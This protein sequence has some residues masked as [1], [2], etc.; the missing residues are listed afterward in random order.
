[1]TRF[2]YADCVISDLKPAG[3]E[4]IYTATIDGQRVDRLLI[5]AKFVR[6]LNGVGKNTKNRVWLGAAGFKKKTLVVLAMETPAGERDRTPMEPYFQRFCAMTIIPIVKGLFAGLATVVLMILPFAAIFDADKMQD[7]MLVAFWGSWLIY[8][9]NEAGQKL[10][11][12]I[13][14][15]SL[16]NWKAG[17]VAS[18]I[19]AKEVPAAF[20]SGAASKSLKK[21]AEK[22]TGWSSL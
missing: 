2:F 4:Y 14:L 12:Y 9:L 3:E 18:L 16:D 11:F 7:P 20:G 15:S 8:A 5:D 22:P 19:T 17:N 13:K 1:M 10:Y 21:A 6:Y